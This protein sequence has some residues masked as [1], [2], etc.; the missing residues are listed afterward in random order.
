M[1]MRIL[2][3]GIILSLVPAVIWSFP[4]FGEACPEITAHERVR[5][6]AVHDGD[7]LRL[8]DGRRVR[9]LAINAPELATDGKAE[10]PLARASRQAVEAF[11]ADTGIVHLSFESRR[12]D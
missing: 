9:L 5:L 10:Q 3:A 2:L 1:L 4:A 7:T 12:T 11:F 8:T 6:S